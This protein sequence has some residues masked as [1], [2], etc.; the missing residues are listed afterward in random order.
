[1]VHRAQ[2]PCTRGVE[3]FPSCHSYCLSGHR[4]SPLTSI[5]VCLWW[6]PAALPAC[7]CIRNHRVSFSVT[8]INPYFEALAY[9]FAN[10]MC[11]GHAFGVNA[12]SFFF[13]KENTPKVAVMPS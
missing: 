12:T 2:G 9:E 5:N 10:Y 4:N 3:A 6:L 8:S 7:L 11:M 1:M 13:T